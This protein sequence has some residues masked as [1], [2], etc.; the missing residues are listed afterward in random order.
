MIRDEGELRKRLRYTNPTL[1]DLHADY[2]AGIRD[3][4][5]W[6]LMED[7]IREDPIFRPWHLTDLIGV[8]RRNREADPELLPIEV[9]LPELGMV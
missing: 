5:K 3:A 2:L 4:L 1:F 6:F 8:G 7:E 9:A